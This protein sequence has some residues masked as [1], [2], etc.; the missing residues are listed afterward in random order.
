[1]IPWSRANIVMCRQLFRYSVSANIIPSF[2][3]SLPVT[4]VYASKCG[5]FFW[6][7]LLRLHGPEVGG[8]ERV[9]DIN[10]TASFKSPPGARKQ[11]TDVAIAALSMRT[12]GRF[13]CFSIDS[14]VAAADEQNSVVAFPQ[15]YS[16]A[17]LTYTRRL[18]PLLMKHTMHH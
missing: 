2:S 7:R 13:I 9:N 14:K 8:C 15:L 17:L 12:N 18:P 3:F 4:V 5:C 1:M 6:R 10:K 11:P 16:V